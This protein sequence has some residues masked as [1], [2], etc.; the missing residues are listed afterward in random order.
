MKSKKINNNLEISEKEIK[1]NLVEVPEPDKQIET[2]QK[3]VL[4]E[5]QLEALA[6]A[7][8]KAQERKQELKELN[9]KSKNLKEE[10]LKADAAEFDK[11]K[12][13]KR[14]R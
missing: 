6:R 5:Q 12:K 3:K 13:K 10:K 4:S 2:K 7:R 9:Y 8:I 14:F 11:L 1:E